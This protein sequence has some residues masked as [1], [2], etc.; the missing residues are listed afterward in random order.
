MMELGIEAEDALEFT[1]WV[2][3]GKIAIKVP[4]RVQPLFHPG[5]S[6]AIALAHEE[7]C[8]LLI[9][10]SNPYEAARRAG[11]QVIGS[12]DFLVFLTW[13]RQIEAGE[14]L[15]RLEGLRRS[16]TPSILE[17]ARR[18]LEQIRKRR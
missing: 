2:K 12:P 18:H 9:D 11:I 15:S 6:Q 16:V 3:A 17:T 8:L 10:D 13:R 7:G 5:E 1:E 4:R 14:A